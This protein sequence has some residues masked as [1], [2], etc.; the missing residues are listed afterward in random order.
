MRSLPP[1]VTPILRDLDMT[2]SQM[3]FIMGSWQLVYVPVAVFAG[4]LL[5]GGLVD[6]T[7]S[8]LPGIV[9]FAV[10]GVIL[11]LI[12]LMVRVNRASE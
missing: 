11:A 9:F 3:G 2:Y 1:L 7:D 12:I 8:F 5:M 10:T 6:M 4:P